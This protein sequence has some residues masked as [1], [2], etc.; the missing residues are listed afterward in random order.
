MKKYAILLLP[1]PAVALSLLAVPLAATVYFVFTQY[2]NKFIAEQSVDYFDIQNEFV[3]KILF[4]NSFAASFNRFSDF[5]FWGILAAIV[6]VVSWFFSVMKTTA[7]NHTI[8]E[9]FNNFQTESSTW[10]RNFII[11]IV[12]KVLLVIIGLY[13]FIRLL[14]QFI[15]DISA[16]IGV[17]LRENTSENIKNI[18]V[19]N[20]VAYV[21]LLFIATAVKMF[22]HINVE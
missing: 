22:R 6:I 10:H 18:I 20:L 21:A 17:Q 16:T 5:A 1:S 13:A 8:V 12:I 7:S 11:K 14:S 2:S 3:R 9:G 19:A 4:D 15:P